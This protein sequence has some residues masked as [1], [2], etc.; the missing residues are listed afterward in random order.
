[1]DIDYGKMIGDGGHYLTKGL[2]YEFKYQTKLTEIPYNL[3]ERD[4]KGTRSMYQIFM[5]CGS[6]YEAAQLLLN[7]W[8]H[9]EVLCKSPW[10]VPHIE[11]WR[12]ER[13]IREAAL[14]K[15]TLIDQAESGNVAAAK[16]LLEG[17]KKRKAG[18]PTKDEVEGEKKKA[19]AVDNKVTDILT[20]MADK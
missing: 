2:F 10:F 8:K 9:W 7:S 5:S 17:A 19:A 6:E 12:E 15:A 16:V 1:M 18:R 3:K 20:R 11:A 13:E 4:W 14:G